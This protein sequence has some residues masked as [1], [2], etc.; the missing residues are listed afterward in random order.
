M[1]TNK[2]ASLPQFSVSLRTTGVRTYA[3]SSVGADTQNCPKLHPWRD[4]EGP[5]ETVVC[6]A[7]R[8]GLVLGHD[9]CQSNGF[10]YNQ[11]TDLKWK[12]CFMV[13][14]AFWYLICL[15]FNMFQSN[16][17]N[18]WIK[19]LTQTQDGDLK[20]I[21]DNS[22]NKKSQAPPDFKSLKLAKLRRTHM[23]ILI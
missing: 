4:P 22:T 12:H 5:S 9:Q 18:L 23:R 10:K 16:E 17:E 3:D 20:C 6:R 19:L 7:G 11:L 1:L 21:R 14:D 13:S 2:H 8:L 15:I